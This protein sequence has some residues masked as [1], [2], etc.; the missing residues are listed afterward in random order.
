MIF[1]LDLAYLGFLRR[2]QKK[3]RKDEDGDSTQSAAAMGG[4]PTSEGEGDVD[5]EG[6]SRQPSGA[7]DPW[8]DFN[9]P[10]KNF[11]SSSDDSGKLSLIVRTKWLNINRH[12]FP[13]DDDTKRKIKVEIKPVAAANGSSGGASG[14]GISS[15]SVDE[16]QRAVGGLELLPT[17]M[18]SHYYM[19]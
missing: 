11:Y 10:S 3:K 4:G 17:P 8:A 9:R 2:R 19:A 16:L 6:F 7:S 13:L 15:A 18:V 12:S 1:I 14:G 5:E